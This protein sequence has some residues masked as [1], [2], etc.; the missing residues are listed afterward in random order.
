MDSSTTLKPEA[1]KIRIRANNVTGTREIEISVDP[2]LRTDDVT[3]VLIDE[4]MLPDTTTY[5]MRDEDSSRYLVGD[6]AIG[7]EITTDA[8][9]TVTPRTHLG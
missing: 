6:N 9:V 2:N 4:L 3:G 7:D 1:G 5:V 8:R